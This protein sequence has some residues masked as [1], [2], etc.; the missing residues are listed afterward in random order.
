[1]C[2]HVTHAFV[3]AFGWLLAPVHN[4]TRRNNEYTECLA[5]DDDHVSSTADQLDEQEEERKEQH[6]ND[7]D[8]EED[9]YEDEYED[10][11][12]YDEDLD[13]HISN[14]TEVTFATRGRAPF[15]AGRFFGSLSHEQQAVRLHDLPGFVRWPGCLDLSS[16]MPGLAVLA[17]SHCRIKSLFSEDLTLP[18]RLR[19]LE[20]TYN[21]L[22]DFE[23]YLP[24]SLRDV[25]LSYNKLTRLPACLENIRD[26]VLVRTTNAAGQQQQ[27]CRLNV[28]NN[29][30]WF[31]EYSD[32]TPGRVNR[33]T[34]VELTRAHDW[35]LL[36]AGKLQRALGQL[37]D[38]H[39][40][41]RHQVTHHKTTYEDAQNVHQ[42][43]VQASVRDAIARLTEL[44]T[45]VTTADDEHETSFDPHFVD[46][47]VKNMRLSRKVAA[48]F[49]VDCASATVHSGLYVT[50]GNLCERLLRFV[51]KQAAASEIFNI[52][53]KEYARNAKV[54]FTGKVTHLLACL[55]GFVDGFAVGINTKDELANQLVAIRNKWARLAG[56]DFAMYVAEALPE[57]MQVLEDACVPALE[58][59]AWLD[60]I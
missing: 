17:V 21:C 1:M 2:E 48:K 24:R 9:E 10:E 3:A 35:G 40:N 49:R 30:F 41:I 8:D 22:E 50:F 4:W 37:A 28:H 45:P 19:R 16:R 56:D 6:A 15:D 29:N 31:C 39:H 42:S 13:H 20:L 55:N 5:T 33:D 57:A 12:E 58:Q 38:S 43:N 60:G 54:C 46:T 47:L 44:T 32:I 53:G 36:C 18:P 25:D 7:N 11:C 51:S 34:M 26:L 52:M 23:V 14:A 27:V 59:E